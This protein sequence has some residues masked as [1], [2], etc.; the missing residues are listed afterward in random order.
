LEQAKE[1]IMGTAA[2]PSCFVRKM[3]ITMVWCAR[4]F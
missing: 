2:N 4:M 1:E 3:T